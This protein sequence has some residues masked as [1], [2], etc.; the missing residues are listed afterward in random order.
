MPESALTQRDLAYHTV[1][2]LDL[3]L[4]LVLL[5]EEVPMTA[6]RLQEWYRAHRR[7]VPGY[8]RQVAQTLWGLGESLSPCCERVCALL[9]ETLRASGAVTL[10]LNI[11]SAPTPASVVTGL[12]VQMVIE[13]LSEE[14]FQAGLEVE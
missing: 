8:G 13:A 7:G 9:C 2:D 3:R 4:A 12:T 11:P 14:E 1:A 6:D 5:G 10:S